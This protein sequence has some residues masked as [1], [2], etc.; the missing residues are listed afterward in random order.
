MNIR[1]PKTVKALAVQR[2]GRAGTLG[3]IM[4]AF[5]GI[6]LAEC[7]VVTAAGY[8]LDY[9]ISQTG[10]LGNMGLRSVLSTFQTVLP[11]VHTLVLMA[12]ELGLANA[13][14]RISREQ[15]AS[16]QSLRMGLSRFW[17]LLRCE[18][19]K[20]MVYGAL[21]FGAMYVSMAV[22][23]VTPMARTSM[24]IL[25]PLMVSTTDVNAV[26]DALLSDEATAM[27]FLQ[28]VLPMYI[29]FFAVFLALM[30]PLSYRL[31]VT[32]YILVD[33]PTVGAFRALTE[34]LRMTRRNAMAF[35]KLDLSFW[36]YY[37][38]SF[39]ATAVSYGDLLLPLV[40]I[41]PK[42]H[43]LVFYGAY[44]LLQAAIY[45]FLRPRMEVSAALIYDAI[46]PKDPPSQ[47]Q[48]LGNIFQM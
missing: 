29:I 43:S 11:Y 4:R 47:G 12:L 38:L 5:C 17:P 31:R 32:S 44:L 45:Y 23:L 9:R 46:R 39:L 3:S 19:L 40:G 16:P 7:L 15:Y 42:V 6:L 35:F 30:L 8:F 36:G 13:M 41:Q 24:A 18:L 2:L 34:S 21:G 14:L 26:L 20:L 10:G 28:A 33:K 27:A 22:F 48:V 37:V 25:E 1:Q